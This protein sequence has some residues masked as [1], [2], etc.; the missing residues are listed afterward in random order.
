MPSSKRSQSKAA[1]AAE[2]KTPRKS[3]KGEVASDAHGKGSPPSTEDNSSATSNS[4]RA[5]NNQ[6][7][8]IEESQ[9]RS[10]TGSDKVSSTSRKFVLSDDSHY[11]PPG[12]TNKSN[13]PM[14]SVYIH[15]ARTKTG[16]IVAWFRKNDGG[17]HPYIR[18]LIQWLENNWE[19]TR[20]KLGVR[21]IG[22]EGSDENPFERKSTGKLITKK[23]EP[24]QTIQL[25]CPVLVHAGKPVLMDRNTVAKRKKFAEN[26]CEV[27]R[28]SAV[29][30]G[31]NYFHTIEFLDD[32]GTK[33]NG[34][35]PFLSE[36][37]GITGTVNFLKVTYEDKT[38]K[39]RPEMDDILANQDWLTAYFTREHRDLLVN[40]SRP[41]GEQQTDNIEDFRL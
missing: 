33:T 15:T 3:Q 28:K 14:A 1:E 22:Y 36:F 21:F 5:E 13:S 17:L 31:Y 30:E 8:S 7:S 18:P 23:N 39:V 2:D 4:S 25:F 24:P 40:S 20:T 26:I 38:T 9:A 41:Q 11:S 29:Q 6:D 12:S 32:F 10:G 34:S 27:N 16:D 37:L 35:Y 19:F